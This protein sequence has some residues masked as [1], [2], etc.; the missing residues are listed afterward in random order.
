MLSITQ[1][2][3]IYIYINKY[4]IISNCILKILRQDLH[5]PFYSNGIVCSNQIR[6]INIS[7]SKIVLHFKNSV[8]L[9]DI[10]NIPQIIN[11]NSYLKVQKEKNL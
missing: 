10:L 4:Y 6:V 2:K 7:F 1:T 5:K 8:L 3:Q 11:T 9:L